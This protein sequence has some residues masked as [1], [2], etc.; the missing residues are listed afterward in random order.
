M[1]AYI[2]GFVVIEGRRSWF[3]LFGANP[4]RRQL[5]DKHLNFIPKYNKNCTV[6]ILT[7][8]L[9]M[10]RITLLLQSQTKTAVDYHALFRSPEKYH[11]PVV[12]NPN[13]G[14]PTRARVKRLYRRDCVRHQACTTVNRGGPL[15]SNTSSYF[16]QALPHILH[17]NGS[18]SSGFGMA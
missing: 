3:T 18:C 5:F 14:R 11:K 2:Y 10:M 8:K 17:S 9:I 4:T 1:P 15:G 16:A 12:R 13:S 7:I 6:G